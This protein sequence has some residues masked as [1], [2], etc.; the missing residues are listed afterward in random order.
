[1]FGYH[2]IERSKNFV[3]AGEYLLAYHLSRFIKASSTADSVDLKANESSSIHIKTPESFET[4]AAKNGPAGIAHLRLLHQSVSNISVFRN[5]VVSWLGLILPK[6]V[7]NYF[8][9]YTDRIVVA[10]IKNARDKGIADLADVEGRGLRN[11]IRERKVSS[12]ANNWLMPCRE[13]KTSMR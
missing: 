11:V 1:M 8:N 13:V 3:V 2:I 6:K 4:G 9:T 10:Y 12:W 5:H 7:G